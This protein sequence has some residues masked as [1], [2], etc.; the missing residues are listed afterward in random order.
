MTDAYVP[1]GAISFHVSDASTFNVGDTILI[2][3]P[4][5]AAWIHF[6]GMD[7]LTRNG[8]PQTWIPV[9]SIIETD[10]TI[11]AISGNQITIEAPLAD[12]F[13]STLLQGS[14]TR[15]TFAGRLSQIGL[16][17]LRVTAPAVD[18]IISSPQFTG[19]A[20]NSAIDSWVSD[21]SFQDTQ[22]TVTVNNTAKRVT[23]DNVHVTHTVTH[24]GDRMADFGIN[25]TEILV[26][27]SSSDGDG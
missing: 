11:T 8:A 15:Y 10:R 12:N 19:L 4:V 3:R 27:K 9:G 7:T 20:M 25:G 23:L 26:N 18:V 17:H 16:E 13:D 6:M 5:T 1:S 14:V 22:N 21:I 24:T 2:H